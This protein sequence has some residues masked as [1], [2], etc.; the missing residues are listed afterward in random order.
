MTK[1][2]RNRRIRRGVDPAAP[3]PD[4][5]FDLFQPGVLP[6]LQDELVE[7]TMQ[8]FPGVPREQVVRQLEELRAERIFINSRYQV[9]MVDVPSPADGWPD[10][11]HLSIKR[12]DKDRIGPEKYREFMAIK[13]HLVGPEN[14]AVE[15]YP[16]RSREYDTVNQYHI[17]V[18]K[19]PKVRFP[20]GYD[21]GQRV[22]SEHTYQGGAKQHPFDQPQH[23]V[24]T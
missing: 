13:D 3:R 11:I 19:D 1:L 9:N 15:L 22:A 10:L 12:R 8:E 24:A 7:K 4:V 20:F 21:F 14:E 5:P 2:S 6:P 23:R 18:V 17:F 16:A